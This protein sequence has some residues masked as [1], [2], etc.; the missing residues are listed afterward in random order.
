[1][2]IT[3][4][5]SLPLFGLSL[6]ALSGVFAACSDDDVVASAVDNASLP[7]ENYKDTSYAPGDN[8]FMYCNGKYWDNH[9][10]ASSSVDGYLV[11][12]IGENLEA[13]Y[14]PKVGFLPRKVWERFDETIASGA[15]DETAHEPYAKAAVSAYIA[16][17]NGTESKEELAKV[18]AEII[19]DGGGTIFSP[20]LTIYNSAENNQE[21]VSCW[22]LAPNTGAFTYFGICN[23]APVLELLG[24]DETLA[25]AQHDLAADFGNS[26]R[27]EEK[28]FNVVK[29][30]APVG[31]VGHE[32]RGAEERFTT[33][34]GKAPALKYPDPAEQPARAEEVRADRFDRLV[35][36][37]LGNEDRYTE[38]SYLDDAS[39]ADDL[40]DDNISEYQEFFDT[41][42]LETLQ[43]ISAC[44]VAL[45]YLCASRSACALFYPELDAAGM[46][47][48]IVERA[49]C[50]PRLL[51]Y[52]QSYNVQQYIVTPEKKQAYAEMCEDF[53][54]AFS[55]RIEKLDWMSSTTKGKAQEKLAAIK[56]YVG[57]PEDWVTEALV[58]LD[59]SIYENIQQARQKNLLLTR[60]VPQLSNAEGWL[61]TYFMRGNNSSETINAFYNSLTNSICIFPVFLTDKCFSESAPDVFNYGIAAVIGHEMTHGFDSEGSKYDKDGIRSDWWTVDDLME[62]KDRYAKLVSSYGN[63][64]IYPEE[65]PDLYADGEKTLSEN[66]AD[67]GG[68]LTAFDA[69]TACATRKGFYGE[70]L[71]KQQRKLLEMYGEF[72]RAKYTFD[73]A[74]T[75]LTSDEHSLCRERI[76]GAVINVDAW[77]DLYDVKPGHKLYL[78]PSRRT[79]IW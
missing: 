43:A 74:K 31:G 18:I 62:F 46:Q 33:T 38:V 45:D 28:K 23:F 34:F 60:Q 35:V 16:R 49:A 29:R 9:D 22:M 21:Y 17:I 67:L 4:I 26:L 78:S 19:E 57:G 71:E 7:I 79:Y 47:Q 64:Q 75:R 39:E 12:E 11:T 40:T 65:N 72:F 30:F 70:E 56:F 63:F 59:G 1:M 44:A 55:A 53:R 68:L 41:Q 5:F 73:F 10:L 37:S 66:I 50:M 20:S 51:S 36:A 32:A 69:Y 54:T 2:N 14:L 48:H 25:Q 76:N 42:S 61:Q 77:Y 52:T 27:A 6:L 15:F 58:T 24:V 3:R 8:F 13:N